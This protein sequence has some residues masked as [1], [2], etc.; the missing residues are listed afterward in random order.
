MLDE[1]RILFLVLLGLT[2][3]LFVLRRGTV[4]TLG[5]VVQIMVDFLL[6]ISFGGLVITFVFIMTRQDPQPL[7]RQLGYQTSFQQLVSFEAAIPG[8]L[9]ND[10]AVQSI[11]RADTD[12]DG[13]RE[14]IVFYHYDLQDGTN[15][16]KGAVYDTDR[17]NPP[18][19]FPYS[20]RPPDRDWLSEG[21]EVT[22]ELVQLVNAPTG[23]DGRDPQEIFVRGNSNTTLTIFMYNENSEQWDYPRD[24]PPRYQPI[25]FF[26][27]TGGVEY[28]PDSKR[29][30]VRD[31]NGFERSQLMARSVYALNPATN[32]F[33]DPFD[34][35][36]L[37]APIISTVDFFSGPPLETLT[38]TYPEKV[39][40]AFEAATCGVV[41]DTLCRNANDIEVEPQLYLAPNSEAYGEF[42]NNNP[43]Y[44]GLTSL[45]NMQEVSIAALRYYPALETD[46]DLLVFGQGRDVVTGEEPQCNVV[47]VVVVADNSPQQ[48][49][50]YSMGIV[51]G[52]WK[53][54]RRL[55]P[56][57]PVCPVPAEL[58]RPLQERS[59][60]ALP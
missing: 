44:F 46:P 32:T 34:S 38:T 17:G 56:E 7:L 37:A 13:F 31:R 16:V 4:L 15:P 51:T 58:L 8:H 11:T 26:R 42:L 48:T 55:D 9:K 19:L 45:T 39:V 59:P 54:F 43:G 57:D 2:V 28:D 36:R 40:L 30:T 21:A 50:W 53:I 3:F 10:I 27:G 12:G 60:E 18:V 41:N 49:L 22:L 14:W 35:Q 23:Q 52:Q 20:L 47:E 6:V 29:V 33:L 1:L 25:G 5:D 24:A